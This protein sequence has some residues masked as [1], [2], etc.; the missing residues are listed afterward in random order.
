MS[1]IENWDFMGLLKSS[2]DVAKNGFI[3]DSIAKKRF[4]SCKD[5]VFLKENNQCTKCGCFMNAKVKVTSASCPIG[6]W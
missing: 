5:C 6:K 1:D 3:E 4:E 2:I